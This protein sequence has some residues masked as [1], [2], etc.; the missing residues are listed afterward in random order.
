MT[1]T[2]S[3]TPNSS[4]TSPAHRATRRAGRRKVEVLQAAVKVLAERGAEATRFT[5]VAQASGVPVST[6]QYYFGSRE[7]LLVAAFRH[8]S[9]TE[10]AA[11]TG[12]LERLPDP[13]DRLARIVDTVLG[14]VHPDAPESGRLW[15]ESWRYGM[16]DAEMRADVLRDYNAW[17]TL[18]ADAIRAG[19]DSGRF[20]AGD[21]G[22]DAIV[23]LSLLDGIGLPAAIGD[24]AVTVDTARSLVLGSME[25]LLAPNPPRR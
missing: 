16:R 1:G 25:R 9:E 2:D 10:T 5:D 4:P 18:I 3:P 7:D 21:P 17:R 20:T 6:L 24:P 11:L 15:I 23:I 22:A 12:E 14:G 19:L 8:A 13:W